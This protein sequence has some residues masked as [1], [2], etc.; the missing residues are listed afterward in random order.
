MKNT[1]ETFVVWNTFTITCLLSD[2]D[3]PVFIFKTSKVENL[4]QP[5]IRKM[6]SYIFQKCFA[7]SVVGQFNVNFFCSLVWMQKWHRPTMTT[8]QT[9][10]FTI[11]YSNVTLNSTLLEAITK[12]GWPYKYCKILQDILQ[13]SYKYYR[14]IE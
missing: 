10:I 8:Q 4:M 5:T 13:E 9:S 6:I 1:L 14:L 11:F 12:K 2:T 3:N 7:L